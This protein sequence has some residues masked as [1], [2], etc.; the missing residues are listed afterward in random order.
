MPKLIMWNYT[1]E[2]IKECQFYCKVSMCKD[3]D[4]TREECSELLEDTRNMLKNSIAYNR[5]ESPLY[6]AV[7]E[8]K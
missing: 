1:E 7:K 5:K 8:D 2:E 6:K 4:C 3:C